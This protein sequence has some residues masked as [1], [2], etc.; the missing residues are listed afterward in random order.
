MIPTYFHF[1]KVIISKTLLLFWLLNTN[2]G[3]R[4]QT[5]SDFHTVMPQASANVIPGKQL[6]PQTKYYPFNI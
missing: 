4:F 3:V 2:P 6:E 1:L 5:L